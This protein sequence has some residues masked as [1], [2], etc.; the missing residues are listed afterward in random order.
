MWKKV[1]FL[2][3]H[4]GRCAFDLRAKIADSRREEWPEP[5][6]RRQRYRKEE[7][8]GSHFPRIFAAF[9]LSKVVGVRRAVFRQSR[10][11]STRKSARR[12]KFKD[13]TD[14]KFRD[15]CSG[16][17]SPRRNDRPGAGHWLG[18]VRHFGPLD[19]RGCDF[20]RVLEVREQDRH[21]RLR[22]CPHSH[23]RSAQLPQDLGAAIFLDGEESESLFYRPWRFLISWEIGR[24]K[25][26]REMDIEQIF[27]WTW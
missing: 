4:S 3:R 23:P 1:W 27:V 7:N 26:L 8:P 25:S 16:G 24:D 20:L 15:C 18:F 21:R 6:L 19:S 17:I 11:E 12:S 13:V 5:G 14:A 10:G 2:G 9:S 22:D